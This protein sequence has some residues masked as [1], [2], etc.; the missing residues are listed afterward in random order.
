MSHELT[1]RRDGTVEFA[2]L[3]GTYRW[4]GLGKEYG[5]GSAIQ[6]IQEKAGMDWTCIGAP[7][8]Y[9]YNGETHTVTDR[10]VQHRS[11][12]GMPLGV[13]SNNFKSVQPSECLEFFRD[14]VES[15]GLQITT[16][17]TLFGGRKMFV[18]AYVGEQSI[19]DDRD[20]VRSYLLLSTALDGSMATTARFTSVCVVCNNT[21]RIATQGDAS[22]RVIHS[23]AFDADEAK[24][25]LGAAPRSFDNF[26]E[27]MRRLA[28]H[29]LS[30][31][32]AIVMTKKLV[33][34]EDGPVSKKILTLF[35]GEGMIG[36]DLAGRHGTAWGWLNSVTQWADHEKRA[37]SESHRL[38]SALFGRGDDL[39]S[40]AL[41]LAMAELA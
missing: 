27:N 36:V 12:T 18:S 39:K 2:Y 34:N 10:V 17:G 38:G 16:A 22:V 23:T 3:E 21:L 1:M 33:K 9:E 4:H 15:L 37:K 25:T 14:L 11:D 40:A 19:I 26:M 30:D 41:E 20:R 24:K 28:N 6:E 32:R 8:S 35:A 29:P 5:V 7:L 13:V 31:E